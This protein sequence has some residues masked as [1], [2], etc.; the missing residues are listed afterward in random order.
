MS[1]DPTTIARR[2]FEEVWN[3]RDDAAVEQLMAP[4]SYGHVEG[5]DVRG[6]EDFRRM[7]DTF[8]AALPDLHIH[9]EDVLASG[10]RVAVRWR[11]SGTHTGDGFGFPGTRQPV[12]V[13]GTTW[14][15]I[16]D[17]QL[18]EGWD[19]WNLGGLLESLRIAGS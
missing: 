1:D 8:L 10:E 19:T 4:E 17:G 14:L 16:R 15:V 6:P 12:N 18:V 13:R 7:R 9:I 3:G 5:G 11:V 2:W